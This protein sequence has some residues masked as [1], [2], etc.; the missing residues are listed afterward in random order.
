MASK[1]DPTELNAILQHAIDLFHEGKTAKAIH[2]LKTSSSRFCDS[3][4]LWGYLG[5]L[6]KESRQFRAAAKSFERAV[7]ISPT[8]EKAS[9]GL[10]F[11]LYRSGKSSNAF[12]EMIRYFHTAGSA[13][14]YI[15]MFRDASFEQ[16]KQH[17]LA[18]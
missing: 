7:E 8:S 5:F 16:A 13:H 10:F 2:L 4:R 14:E 17:A 6:Q 3:G 11:S 1:T 9:L 12:N 15:N 18:S